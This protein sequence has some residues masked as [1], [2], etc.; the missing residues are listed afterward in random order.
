MRLSCIILTSDSNI[1]KGFCIRHSLQSVLNQKY[2]DFDVII[3]DNSHHSHSSQKLREYI[4]TIGSSFVSVYKPEVPM[5][6]GKGRNFWASFAT[7]DVFIF[8]DDDAILLSD[9]S[10]QRIAE[11]VEDKDFWYWAKRWWTKEGDWFQDNAD[12]V[13]E[14]IKLQWSFLKMN[15]WAAPDFIRGED[16][17]GLQNFSFIGHFGFCKR[18]LF[19]EIWGFPDLKWCDFEDDWF[20]YLC[21]KRGAKFK[22][23]ADLE[24]VH[25]THALNKNDSNIVEYYT[26]LKSDWVFWFYPANALKTDGEI[27]EKLE[28]WHVDYRLIRAYF[29]YKKKFEESS[30]QAWMSFYSLQDYL[31]LFRA[32][33]LT[34]EINL[35]VQKSSSDFDTLIPIL[36]SWID[37][38]LISIMKDGVVKILLNFHYFP[39]KD[40]VMSLNC[41]PKVEYNQFPCDWSSREARLRLIRERFP[42][43]DYLKIALLGDDD[44][45]SPLLAQESWLDI[46]V[47]EWD[48]DIVDTLSTLPFSNLRVMQKD[49]RQ[50]EILGNDK[51]KTFIVDPPYTK[52]WILLFLYKGMQLID[53]QWEYEEF[54]LIINAW[55]T[56]KFFS[57]ISLILAQC[58]VYIK[59]IRKNF[60]TYHLPQNF[61]ET[62]RA[63]KFTEDYEL[64]NSVILYSSSSDL[65]ILRSK[66]PDLELLWKNIRLDS[67]YDH[68]I[69]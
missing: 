27:I 48:K 44:L 53:F 38:H 67:I 41:T 69:F 6:R 16:I 8:L 43:T 5:S 58:G 11:Y 42:F 7:G 40:L 62:A 30:L 39:V 54:Y 37:A 36:E 3:V 56:Q 13:L 18:T 63:M 57:E 51:V 14:D 52:H 32:L 24:V 21:F 1:D 49:F 29:L 47:F 55:M 28:K 50:K 15:I 12:N 45:L 26:M 66:N 34:Q 2:V 4:D 61:K 60:S 25:V 65:Y 10:F 23:L 22:S 20:M 9:V 64:N 19:Q 33:Q 31:L 68:S 17:E 35:F 59:E 46:T